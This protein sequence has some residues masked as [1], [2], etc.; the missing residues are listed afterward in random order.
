VKID[1]ATKAWQVVQLRLDDLDSDLALGGVG[2]TGKLTG[3]F[4]L[5]D[6][7]LV[8]S[9]PPPP[10]PTAVLEEYAATRPQRF[11]LEQ[12]YPNPFNSEMVIRCTLPV[13]GK[14]EL[15]LYNLAGQKVV[16]LVAG[17]RE[18][19]AYALRW[20]G[21]DDSG[22]ELATGVYLYRLQVGERKE[23]RKL[24]LLR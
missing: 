7:R 21:R 8:A 10:P 1:M 22:R 15:A 23:V 24:L 19:G 18:A 16:A 9:Q 6:L 11:S 12:N 13:S 20:D 4:Y 17:V 2:L 3:T 5:D 14:V